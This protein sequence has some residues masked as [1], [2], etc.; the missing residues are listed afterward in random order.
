MTHHMSHLLKAA[1]HSYFDKDAALRLRV[2]AQKSVGISDSSLSIQVNHAIE[3]IEILD[4]QLEKIE[5][6]HFISIKTL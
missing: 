3:Q 4:S 2:L 5:T 6:E 1:S